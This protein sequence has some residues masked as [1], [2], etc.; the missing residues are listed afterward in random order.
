M[1]S[2]PSFTIYGVVGQKLCI[3]DKMLKGLLV[4]IKRA[5]FVINGQT[6]GSC[7]RNQLRELM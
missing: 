3:A 2:I 1:P 5:C 7:L 6:L 4:N